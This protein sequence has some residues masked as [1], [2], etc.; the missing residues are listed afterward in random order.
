[1]MQIAFDQSR[2]AP[3][4]AYAVFFTNGSL[5]DEVKVSNVGKYLLKDGTKRD[6]Y[7]TNVGLV[8][9]T[10]QL[11]TDTEISVDL[12]KKIVNECLVMPVIHKRHLDMIKEREDRIK[13]AAKKVVFVDAAIKAFGDDPSVRRSG[14]SAVKQLMTD[15][16]MFREEYEAFYDE[17]DRL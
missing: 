2:R 17:I 3:S 16:E 8:I 11:V 10:P 5:P 14:D 6:Y 7:T 1:M 13:S 9:V 15:I 4:P 12:M